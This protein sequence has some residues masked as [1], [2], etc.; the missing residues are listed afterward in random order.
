MA[1]LDG[2][3]VGG[4]T[5]G[6][7][8][9]DTSSGIAPTFSASTAYTAGQYVWYDSGSGAKLYRFTADHAAGAWAGTDATEVKLGNDVSALESAIKTA[10][11]EQSVDLS[12][13]TG[14]KR[15]ISGENV[16]IT[17][18]TSARSMMVEI[19]EG[20]FEIRIK[21]NANGGIY[22]LLKSNANYSIDSPLSAVDFSSEYPARVSYSDDVTIKT[23][24]DT[25]YLYFNTVGATGTNYIPQ[26]IT[27]CLIDIKKTIEA[28]EVLNY[29]A[30]ISGAQWQIGKYINYSGVIS[31]GSTFGVSQFFMVKP[32]DIVLFDFALKDSNGVNFVSGIHEYSGNTWLRTATKNRGEFLI[33][34]NDANMIRFVFGRY[35]ST[36][37]KLTQNDIKTYAK[38]YILQKKNGI[39]DGKRVSIIGTSDSTFAGFIPPEN[40]SYYT[41]GNYGVLTVGNCWWHIGITENG[42]LPLINDSWSGTAVADGVRTPTQGNAYTPLIDTSRCQ[43][44]HAYQHGGTSSD[45]LV[46]SENIGNLRHSPW[47]AD[48]T[49][50]TVGEYVK[51]IDPDVIIINGGGNDYIHNC[52][53]GTYDGHTTLS[54]DALTTFREAYANLINRIQ[55]RYP[56][57][58][59]ICCTPIYLVKPDMSNPP[60]EAERRQVNINGIGLTYKD[61]QDAIKEI[62]TLKGCPVING[63]VHGFSRYNYYNLFCSDS[64][65]GPVH[66]NALGHMVFGKDFAKHLAECVPGLIDFA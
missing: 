4:T 1:I 22:A 57:A 51:E 62:A 25:K 3:S 27:F 55:A 6:L 23:Y 10:Y 37:I 13:L 31:T 50:W 21:A 24:G 48:Q 46:T 36:S 16:Y 52:P 64:E 29:G 30:D 28:E 43:N 17:V 53:M 14:T 61:Y 34:P 54:D 65:R 39:L 11:T 40:V 2:V 20:T 60:T 42:G 8:D 26:N 49:A 33:I 19:P 12:L 15:I 45:T 7:R 38:T 59:V 5:Y 58:L 47:D 66:P 9:N 35:S 41:G 32:G 56:H 18:T 44:L 63:F